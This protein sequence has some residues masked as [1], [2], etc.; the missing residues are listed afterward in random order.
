MLE[1]D[2]GDGFERRGDF[3]E[4]FLFGLGA[5]VLVDGGPFHLFAVGRRLEIL[6]RVADHAGRIGG[7]DFDVAA[8]EELEEALGVLL[9]VVGRFQE[10]G[11][12][13]FEAGL[14][15]RAGEIGIAVAGLGL[16][17][18]SRQQVFLGL[19]SLDRFSHVHSLLLRF[20][21]S[22][23]GAV[24]AGRDGGGLDAEM[25][26]RRLAGFEE[27]TIGIAVGDELNPSD[28]VLLFHG[29]GHRADLDLVAVGRLLDDRNVLFL[30]GV[31]GIFDE[32]LHGLAAADEL[33]A[34][35]GQHFDDVAAQGALVDRQP[36]S[37]VRHGW[38]S[39]FYFD[40]AGFE[41]KG[42]TGSPRRRL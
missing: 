10:E 23:H 15:G 3:E 25:R 42:R 19:G 32:Q 9:L 21:E 34:P 6:G 12:D 11:R 40:V 24:F 16:A 30:G 1:L 38:N 37:D 35:R 33:A 39:F 4:A 31:D 41:R 29:M 2:L 8:L 36:G 14:L 22:V 13:L 27:G 5:K 18:E 20:P 17:G 26:F 7:H 28:V